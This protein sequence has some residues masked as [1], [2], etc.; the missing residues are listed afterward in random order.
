MGH[1]GCRENTARASKVSAD[2]D[3]LRLG[4]ENSA[5][6]QVQHPVAH[7]QLDFAESTKPW[8]GHDDAAI[9]HRFD[10]FNLLSCLWPALRLDVS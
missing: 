6:L 3:D 5:S 2:G 8:H 9:G 10:D 1:D 4:C 7:L